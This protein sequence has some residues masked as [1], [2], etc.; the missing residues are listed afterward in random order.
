MRKENQVFRQEYWSNINQMASLHNNKEV[1]LSNVISSSSFVEKE[2]QINDKNA[3]C[4]FDTG[5]EL[6]LANY[7][8][9]K[10]LDL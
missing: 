10:D 8:T 9:F 6:N 1:N 5:S 2:I 7:E 3:K 4:L